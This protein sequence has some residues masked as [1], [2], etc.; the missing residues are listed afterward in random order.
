MPST[1]WILTLLCSDWSLQSSLWCSTPS[2]TLHV[3][4]TE[5]WDL[6]PATHIAS[7]WRLV[8]LQLLVAVFQLPHSHQAMQ[9]VP[10]G[11]AAG[12]PKPDVH[13]A[14][15]CLQPAGNTECTPISLGY[16]KLGQRNCS[17][18]TDASTIPGSL[19]STEDRSYF[20]PLPQCITQTE[21]AYQWKWKCILPIKE[22]CAC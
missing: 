18:Q 3:H 21:P 7:W 11:S 19:I 16:M 6:T 4:D 2:E 15:L 14:L 17:P 9:T 12:S 22:V 8:E 20:G 13:Q 5:T 10:A 1:G